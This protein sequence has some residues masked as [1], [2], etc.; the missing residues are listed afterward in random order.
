MLW[1]HRHGV[2]IRLAGKA[3]YLQ[4]NNLKRLAHNGSQTEDATND[5]IAVSPGHTSIAT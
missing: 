1:S 4:M 2:D 5:A 3:F